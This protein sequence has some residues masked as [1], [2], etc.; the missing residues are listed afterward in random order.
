MIYTLFLFLLVTNDIFC[1]PINSI[2]L[3]F[4]M[5]IIELNKHPDSRLESLDTLKSL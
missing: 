4:D 3:D 2:L 1:M 5:V